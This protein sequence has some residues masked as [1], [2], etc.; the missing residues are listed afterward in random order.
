MKY[1]ST[2]GEKWLQCYLKVDFS[3]SLAITKNIFKGSMVDIL[4]KRA[5]KQ[6][7]YNPQLDPKK[8]GKKWKKRKRKKWEQI[9][10]VTN[11]VY[12]KLIITINMA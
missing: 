3:N 12:I 7:I 5:R 11:T 4:K 1:W 2:T 6:I 10:I 8:A 9:K